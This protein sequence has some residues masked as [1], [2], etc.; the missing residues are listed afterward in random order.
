MT[1]HWQRSYWVLHNGLLWGFNGSF[2]GAR[3]RL[4]LPILG[5]KLGK[6][7][8]SSR[9]HP[10]SFTVTINPY[11]ME[12]E[13]LATTEFARS[14]CR[15]LVACGRPH[16]SVCFGGPGP[17]KLGSVPAQRH[18]RWLAGSTVPRGAGCVDANLERDGVQGVQNVPSYCR[19]GCARAFGGRA[20]RQCSSLGRTR[21]F[22]GDTTVVK[23]GLIGCICQTPFPTVVP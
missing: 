1:W 18:I 6:T 19:Q 7:P 20:R 12:D 16:A 15:K 8:P 13:L 11:F 2:L 22:H 3:L 4:V 10:F 9:A 21:A 5:A 14:I 17:G 23:R